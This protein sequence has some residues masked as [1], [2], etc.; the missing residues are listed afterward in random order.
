MEESGGFREVLR[1]PFHLSYPNLFFFEDEIY[2]IPES[3]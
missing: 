1:E 3:N 2:M